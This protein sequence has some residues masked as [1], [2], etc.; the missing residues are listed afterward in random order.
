M[1]LLDRPGAE[2]SIILAGHVIPPA[3]AV[4]NPAIELVNAVLGGGF[5]S[6][7]NMNLREDKG[8]SYGARSL[9]LNARAQRPFIVYAPVQTDRTT[10]S[11]REIQAELGALLSTRP[12]TDEEVARAKN[13][14]TL[15]L[16][17]RNETSSDIAGTLAESIVY[18][19]P[20]NYHEQYISRVR[21][22]DEAR[23]RD[24]AD[25]LVHQDALTWVIV[26]DL[27]RIEAEVRALEIGP[28]TL[29]DADG[30]PQDR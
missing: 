2:Q 25:T 10:D 29:L 18:D 9:I 21:S 12:L 22:A 4:D 14:L 15:T 8:W 7:I 26:G 5:T 23:L 11:I 24:A 16:P 20:W 13:K 27:S 17:G 1:Y 19:L 28:V 6:R 30:R 3:K